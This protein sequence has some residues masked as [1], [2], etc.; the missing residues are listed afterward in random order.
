[1]TLIKKTFDIMIR[2]HGNIR[3]YYQFK[4]IGENQEIS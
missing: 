3:E 2:E 4:K 1:M